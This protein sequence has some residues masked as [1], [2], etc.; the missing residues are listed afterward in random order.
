MNHLVTNHPILPGLVPDAEVLALARSF[1]A[2]EEYGEMRLDRMP[3]TLEREQLSKRSSQIAVA[4][5]PLQSRGADAIEAKKVLADLF[6]GYGVM[7]AMDDEAFRKT[8][9]AYVYH[10][11]DVPLFALRAAVDDF[12]NHRVYDVDRKTGV[13]TSVGLD[14]APA[15]YRIKTVCEKH[16]AK[17]YAEQIEFD[18]VLRARKTLPPAI[19]AE[20]RARVGEALRQFAKDFR[21]S[22]TEDEA[23]ENRRR[24][25]RQQ[26]QMR[27]EE[28]AMLAEYERLGIP[29]V[30]IGGVIASPYLARKLGA[31]PVAPAREEDASGRWP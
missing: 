27:R 23:E 14:H 3:T 20:E 9:A 19:P 26:E 11:R 21:A 2:V 18:R 31:M 1:L 4:L 7:R 24:V 15:S 5:E 28:A 17:L 30:R 22:V 29:P 10:L 13:R 8:V 12:Q 25:E 6:M 16:A